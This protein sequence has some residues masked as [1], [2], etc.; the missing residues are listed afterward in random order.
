MDERLSLTLFAHV[1][2][3]PEAELDLAEAALLIAEVE[4]PSIDLK[5]PTRALDALADAARASVAWGENEE[6]R[7]ERAVRYLYDDAGFHG[8]EEDYYDPH[9]SFLHQVIAHR[10]GIPITLAVVLMEVCRRVGIDARGVSFPGHFLV[11]SDTPRGTIVVDPFSGRPLTRE[12]LRALYRRSSGEDKD[13]PPRVLEPATKVQILARILGNLRGIYESRGDEARLRRVLERL[14]V[15]APAEALQ[16]EITRLGGST[17][18]PS[19]GG[20]LN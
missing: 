13:P 10:T 3:R 5:L 20:G 18:W 1:A 15:I 11:R 7:L 16:R 19:G 9:N 6:S 2:T 12:G 17:P 14:Q 4:G 8:N